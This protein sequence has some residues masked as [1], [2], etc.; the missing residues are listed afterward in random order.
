MI[1]MSTDMTLTLKPGAMTLSELRAV[2][3]AQAR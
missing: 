2:W 1:K 3:N